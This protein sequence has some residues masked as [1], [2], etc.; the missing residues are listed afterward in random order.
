VLVALRGASG[1]F[2]PAIVLGE[3]YYGARKSGRQAENVARVAT[4]AAAVTVLGCDVGR[5]AQYGELKAVLRDRG[6]PIPENDL[7][8][9]AIARQHETPLVTRD[10]HFDAIPDLRVER[11]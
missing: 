7:W 11:W 6:T 1:G 5:A 4:L 8:I 10:A 2:L 3:L 9:A